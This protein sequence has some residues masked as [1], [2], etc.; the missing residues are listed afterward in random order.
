MRS[1]HLN[2]VVLE[3]VMIVIYT[4]LSAYNDSYVIFA[5]MAQTEQHNNIM[6][7]A[8]HKASG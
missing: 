2:S 6:F 5:C 8:M 4:T 1:N 3:K 7:M